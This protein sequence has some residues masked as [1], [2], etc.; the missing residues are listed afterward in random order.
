MR[1]LGCLSSNIKRSVIKQNCI[2]LRFCFCFLIYCTSKC[3][4]SIIKLKKHMYPGL[5]FVIRHPTF[6]SSFRQHFNL[7][8]TACSFEKLNYL[9]IAHI[10]TYPHLLVVT[11]I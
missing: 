8:N 6:C 2:Y 5:F 1:L 11:Y 4:A 7:K 3:A 9:D 10:C